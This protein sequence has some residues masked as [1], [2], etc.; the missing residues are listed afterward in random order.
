MAAKTLRVAT[1]T[2]GGSTLAEARTNTG[3]ASPDGGSAELVGDAIEV[4]DPAGR[5]LVRYRDGA[6][7][8]APL[9]GDLRLAAPSGRVHIEGVDVS[10]GATRDVTV[11]AGRSAA[12]AVTALDEAQ[13]GAS[14]RLDPTNARVAARSIELRG[15]TARTVVAK[16]EVIATAVRTTAVSIETQARTIQETAERVSLKAKELT[17]HVTG[18]FDAKLGRVRSLVKGAFSVRSK[19]VQMKA[20]D[21]ATVDG[22][23]VLLG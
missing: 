9:S 6:L 13:G 5:M 17:H 22:K 23:R 11:S 3:I 10:L 19:T 20:T 15:Q 12:V 8:I 18:L 7:E 21:D 1:S 16:A 4:R 2:R 14:L